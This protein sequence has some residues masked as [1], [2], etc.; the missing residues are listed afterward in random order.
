MPQKNNNGEVYV[1]VTLKDIYDKVLSIEQKQDRDYTHIRY[2][3]SALGTAC[4]VAGLVF[5]WLITK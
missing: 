2:L 5:W 1:K 3:W 4:S